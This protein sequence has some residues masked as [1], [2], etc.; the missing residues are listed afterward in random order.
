MRYEMNFNLN[1]RLSASDHT[2]M[3]SDICSLNFA[4]A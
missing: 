2:E 1:V 4:P 3:C